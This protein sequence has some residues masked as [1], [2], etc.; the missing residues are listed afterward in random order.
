MRLVLAAALLVSTIAV[1]A[2]TASS[3]PGFAGCSAYTT[4]HPKLAVRPTSIIAACGDGNFYF[5]GLHWTSW[6]PTA[7]AAGTAHLNDCTPNCAAG[8]FHTY[9]AHVSLSAPHVCNGRTEL[10]RLSWIFTGA[11]PK[12]QASTGFQTFRCR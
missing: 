8:K 1:G 11:H 4:A 10:T 7:A 2:A 3:F 5:S 6:G 12:G 9:P